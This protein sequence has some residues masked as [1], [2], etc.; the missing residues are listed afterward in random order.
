MKSFPEE[1]FLSGHFATSMNQRQKGVKMAAERSWQAKI[2]KT[3][4]KIP[5]EI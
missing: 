4:L 2:L 5:V 3:L 1:K